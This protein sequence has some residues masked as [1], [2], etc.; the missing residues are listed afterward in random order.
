DVGAVAAPIE[1]AY[2]GAEAATG[3]TNE[4]DLLVSPRADADEIGRL[5]ADPDSRFLLAEAGP[6]LVACVLLQRRGEECYAGEAED[7]AFVVGRGG[8]TR[9]PYG[10]VGDTL[11]TLEATQLEPGAYDEKV[12]GAGLGIVTERSLTGDPE[13]AQ[14]VSVTG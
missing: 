12:Y 5:V 2:R 11:S 3:W 7:T 14:L 13:V 6:E 8:T 1:R 4:A 10:R 9:V